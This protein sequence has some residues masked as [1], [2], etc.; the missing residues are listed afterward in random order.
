M[1]LR[2]HYAKWNKLEKD[3]YNYDVTYV[4]SKKYNKQVNITKNKMTSRY[5]DYLY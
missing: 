5:R 4:E 1:D 3:K 2:G